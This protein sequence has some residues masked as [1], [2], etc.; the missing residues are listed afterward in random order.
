MTTD[1]RHNSAT[2]LLK[3]RVNQ[4][5]LQMAGGCYRGCR[6]NSNWEEITDGRR[7]DKGGEEGGKEDKGSE[8]VS[9][10]ND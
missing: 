9:K 1:E 4:S 10:D 8:A 2:M 6:S 3:R 5:R 7:K